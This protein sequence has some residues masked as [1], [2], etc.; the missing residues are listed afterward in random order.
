[1]GFSCFDTRNFVAIDENSELL[2]SKQ[3]LHLSSIAAMPPI[4]GVTPNNSKNPLRGAVEILPV[5]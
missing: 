3:I 4:P 2:Y 5:R 1:M